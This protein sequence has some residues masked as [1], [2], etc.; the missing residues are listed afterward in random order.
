MSKI[1]KMVLGIALAVCVFGGSVNLCYAAT[2][3]IDVGVTATNVWGNFK[4]G[5]AGHHLKVTVHYLE[6]CS[7]GSVNL[8][9]VSAHQ[10]G[11]FIS[12]YVSRPSPDGCQYISGYAEGYVDDKLAAVSATARP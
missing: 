4:Y 8:D 5:E 7:D 3:S 12:V 9:E 10:F 6:T 11:N 2:S 1:R